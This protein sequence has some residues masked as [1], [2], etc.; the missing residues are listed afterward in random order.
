MVE[1]S[2]SDASI[3]FAEK[4]CV[5]D[6]SLVSFGCEVSSVAL[7]LVLSY[8]ARVAGLSRTVLVFFRSIADVD[9][10]D[11]EVLLSQLDSSKST[12]TM[13]SRTLCEG[14]LLVDIPNVLSSFLLRLLLLF[15]RMIGVPRIIWGCYSKEANLQNRV[16]WK[17][18]HI[19][20]CVIS[21][22]FDK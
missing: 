9:G 3:W 16:I 11:V 14:V 1:S 12:S 20:L 8:L 18:W 19:C 15:D 7:D 21:I 17:M 22:T 2:D 13:R 6:S 10:M 4:H 5:V